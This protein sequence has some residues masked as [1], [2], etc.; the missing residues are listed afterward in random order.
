MIDPQPETAL[1]F[2]YGTLQ[3]QAVQMKLFGRLLSGTADTLRGFALVPLKIDDEEV[4]AIS[5]QGYHTMATFTGLESDL[6]SGTVFTLSP[7]EL[8][9][10]DDYEVPA[11]KQRAWY[12]SLGRVPG[13]TSMPASPNDS[14]CAIDGTSSG[15]CSPSCA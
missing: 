7:E 6:V 13:C 5:G 9:R 1:L 14:R 10:A 12:F 2:S 11:V 4:V 8:R 3:L 15:P